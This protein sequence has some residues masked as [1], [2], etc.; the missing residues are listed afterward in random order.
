MERMPFPMLIDNMEATGELHGKPCRVST[1]AA[2][3]LLLTSRGVD[4]ILVATPTK[5]NRL[6][7]E[8]G[9]LALPPERRA[10]VALIDQNGATLARVLRYLSP[11]RACVAKWPEDAFVEFLSAFVY[12]VALAAK[13]KASV[14]T[15]AVSVVRGFIPIVDP[16]VF[17]REARFRFAE[18]AALICSYEPALLSHGVLRTEV[19]TGAGLSSRLWKLIETAEFHEV[20]EASGK[21]GWVEHPVIATRHLKNTLAHYFQSKEA[22][23]LLKSTSAVAGLGAKAHPSL[24][25]AKASADVLANFAESK[26]G[27]RPPFFPLGASKEGIHRMSLASLSPNAKAAPGTIFSFTTHRGQGE[28]HSWLNTGEE[29]KLER[30]SSDLEG[31]KVRWEAAQKALEKIF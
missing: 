17:Q 21:L 2:T 12:Q 7:A 22:N 8:N 26:E 3:S 25:I 18:L 23:I 13:H 27:Y 1:L 9:L 15:D 5:S 31:S 6:I 24:E 14:G 16:S 29:G 19:D 30:E 28:S 4:K 11:L 10:N 20:V